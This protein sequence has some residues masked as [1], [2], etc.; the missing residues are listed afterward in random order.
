MNTM[1][2][3]AGSGMRGVN[4]PLLRRLLP[5]VL[6]GALGATLAGCADTPH[7]ATSLWHCRYCAPY[8]KAG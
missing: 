1:S 6:V 7:P 4:R 3:S 8:H 2:H 5:L